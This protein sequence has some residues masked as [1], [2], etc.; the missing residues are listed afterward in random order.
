MKNWPYIFIAW[1]WWL[2]YI[3]CKYRFVGFSVNLRN[4][5]TR[6]LRTGSAWKTTPCWNIHLNTLCLHTRATG[7]GF[8][9][10]RY[11][12]VWNSH[13]IFPKC[14]IDCFKE[15]KTFVYKRQARS[16]R[17]ICLSQVWLQTELNDTKSY[18]QLIIKITIS[19][20]RKSPSYQTTGK[21][22]KDA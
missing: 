17:P 1:N 14:L 11:R 9:N 22:T 15:H 3:G 7:Y 10:T 18:Y 20:K 12:A 16:G 19:E 21:L 13:L 8:Q 2:K 4:D 5:P 6:T